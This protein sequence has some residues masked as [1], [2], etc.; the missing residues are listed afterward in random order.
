MLYFLTALLLSF[1]LTDI[2][3]RIMS[4]M[5]IIDVPDG[6]RKLHA[7]P[8]ALGGGLA[9]FLS[10]WLV[11]GYI[12]FFTNLLGKNLNPLDL[13]GVFFGSLLLLIIGL[14]DD[15]KN[16]SAR[17]RLA[18]TVL[19]VLI[20]IVGGVGID[21]ITNPLGGVLSLNWGAVNIFGQ[22]FLLA[23]DVLV[24][25]WILGMTYTVKI[26]DGLDG[27]AT[28]I[29]AIGALVICGVAS[30]ERWHQP[31]MALLALVFAGVCLGFLF[32]NFSP[33]KIFLGEGGG[34]FLGYILGV[35]AV[36]SG[37]K[38]ATALLVMAIP[39]LDLIR[40]V[41]VRLRR[42]QPIFQGDREHL[43]FWLRDRGFSEKTTVLGLY[44]VAIIFGSLTL[45]LQSIGKLLALLFLLLFM[46]ALALIIQNKQ[47][48]VQKQ[49]Q[50]GR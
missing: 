19:A 25:L 42:G 27:L 1:I 4:K 45:F 39:I 17:W 20:A 13:A 22:T 36:I 5:R 40:V 33:A 30:G 7:R 28:G 15:K 41:I 32:W 24:F 48:Y 8:V 6:T 46:G 16:I 26:L 29:T 38:I 37:G 49:R 10:F 43:H 23:A 47:S 12:V 9:L 18:A 34:L 35:L 3:K 2:V 31:D 14:W 21:K 44:L 11:V 50:R